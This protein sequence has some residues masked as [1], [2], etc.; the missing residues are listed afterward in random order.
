MKRRTQDIIN[1]LDGV[2]KERNCNGFLIDNTEDDLQTLVTKLICNR[3]NKPLYSVSLEDKYERVKNIIQK[4][5]EQNLLVVSTL[6]AVELNIIRDWDRFCLIAD[7][8][9]L[10][11]DNRKSII[12][13]YYDL[14]INYSSEKIT[15][16]NEDKVVFDDKLCITYSEIEDVYQLSNKQKMFEGIL[17]FNQDPIKHSFWY[18][19]T[20]RQKI[21]ISY[22]HQHIKLTQHKII[23]QMKVFKI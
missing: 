2:V 13:L 20:S 4:A 23:Q 8:Y 16:Y 3:C 11:S 22:L 18:G 10:A 1:W 19:L 6:N 7:V 21:V 17:T 12:D 14:E 9:P 15:E 5:N